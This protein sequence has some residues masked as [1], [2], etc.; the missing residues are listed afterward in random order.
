MSS[1]TVK[2]K[3]GP[4]SKKKFLVI[5]ETETST[6]STLRSEQ[7]S[8]SSDHNT[9]V[10]LMELDDC[11][12]PP[13]PKRKADNIENADASPKKQKTQGNDQNEETIEDI[14]SFIRKTDPVQEVVQ[15]VAPAP[16]CQ[17]AVDRRRAKRPFQ[18]PVCE[19]FFRSEMVLQQHLAK[20]HFWERLLAM[21]RE[22]ETPSG[23]MFQCSEFPCQYLHKVAVVV[24]GHLA[25][26]HKVVFRIARSLFPTFTLPPRPPTVTQPTRE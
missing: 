15:E 4:K 24:S 25:T 2:Y 10:T 11:P 5:K 12:P 22:T 20:I 9:S 16:P 8:S 26:E 21:P 19:G 13:S 18:C 3:P 7:N 14:Q 23:A 17:E 1:E 6:T